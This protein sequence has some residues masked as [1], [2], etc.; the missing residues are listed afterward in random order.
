MTEFERARR[1]GFTASELERAKQDI[2]RFYESADKERK[3]SESGGYANEYVDLFL[4]KIAS[5][6]ID[7]EYALVQRLLPGITLDDANQRI[8]NL[9]TADNRAIIVQAPDKAD[10]K[11]PGEAELTAV[12]DAVAGEEAR[13]VHRPVAQTN[14]MD[15]KPAPAAIV[16]EKTL[17]DLGVTEI[18]LANGVRVIMKPTTFKKDE[19][20]FSATSPGGSSLVTDADYPEAAVAASWINNSGVGDLTETELTK[21]LSGKLVSVSPVIGELKEGFRGSASPDDLETALQLVYLYATRP[22]QRRQQLP[23]AAQSARERA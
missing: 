9:V 6:G 5:P 19:V 7:Y 18:T 17:P 8:A 1:Y 22:A 10:L 20:V 13:A 11:L 3:T 15:Q 12:V 4:R 2:L 23:G 21:L 16:S 14:L